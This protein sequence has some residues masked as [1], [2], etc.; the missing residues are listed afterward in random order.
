MFSGHHVAIVTPMQADG[1]LDLRAWDA[2]VDMHVEQRTQG[3]VVGGTTGESPTVSDAEM[4]SLVLRARARAGT[5]LQIMAGA[6]TNSTASSVERACWLAGLGVDGLLVVTPAYN[7]PTQEGLF[8]HYRAIASATAALPGS[9]V[10]IVLYNVP[11][12]TSVDMLP[13]TV[14]RLSRVPGIV[15][16]K[17]AVGDVERVRELVATCGPRFAVLSGD[18]ATTRAS[19]AAGVRGVISVTGNVAPR[20]MSDMVAAAL[21]GDAARAAAIDARLAALHESLFVEANPIPVKWVLQ[22]MG[23]IAPGI[24]LPLTPLA[25]RFHERLR[26]AM[27]AAGIDVTRPVGADAVTAEAV[28]R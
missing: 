5:R 4:R 13:Q 11:G 19:I 21:A 27:Q 14:A 3:I 15:A 2:L 26:A 16:I 1:S 20:L 9:G 22:Q 25:A 23:L 12:R 28:T 6:G 7:K 10:P 17:E 24:R 8:L 18:D